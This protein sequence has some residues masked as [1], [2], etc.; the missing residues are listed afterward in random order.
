MALHRVYLG[1]ID[2]GPEGLLDLYTQRGRADT[3]AVLVYLF[4]FGLVAD[5][6]YM[7]GSAPLKSLSVYSA[8][9]S[10]GEAFQRNE[11]NEP[12]PVF[13]FVLSEESEDYTS[14]LRKRLEFLQQHGGE[15]AEQKAYIANHGTDT[16]KM[17]DA[18]LS[19]VEIPKR[20]RS[21]ST[22]F[23][24]TLASS[25]QSGNI[26]NNHVTDE[27]A[28]EAMRK[29]QASENIQT[30]AFIDSLEVADA[31]QLDAIYD[32][33]REKYRR[34]NAYGSE[35]I[36]SDERLQFQVRNVSR[37]L[38]S[39]GLAKVLLS[40]LGLTASLLFKLRGLKSFREL[41]AEYFRCQSQEDINE[42]LHIIEQFSMNGKVRG[43]LKQSPAAA[44]AI[45]FEALNE[46]QI[47]YKAINKGLEHLAKALLRD[48]FDE[49]FAKRCYRVLNG[50]EELKKE[51]HHLTNALRSR[52]LG[53]I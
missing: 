46:A 42:L 36:D 13:A 50:L 10:L 22:A 47:G 7:Q 39:I 41:K 33:V 1:R 6:V 14:Y 3:N 52:S 16:S 53:S 35:C 32:L 19:L 21:V 2:I 25:L 5:E 44:I 45:I 8:Y 34:S 37:F 11:V 9:R 24:K 51:M 28:N 18:D 20:T 17:L 48:A 43:I 26:G 31:R 4:M 30:F 15:N 12:H 40:P 38:K 49:V 23:R 27:T 29:L